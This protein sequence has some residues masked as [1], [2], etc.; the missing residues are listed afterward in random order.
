VKI[1]TRREEPWERLFLNELDTCLSLGAIGSQAYCPKLI[2]ADRERFVSA[3]EWRSGSYKGLGRFFWDI[4]AEES[5]RIVASIGW[6]RRVRPSRRAS[7]RAFEKL[8]KDL[9]ADTTLPPDLRRSVL[10]KASLGAKGLHFA[11]G[12]L[13]ASNLLLTRTDLSIIDWE[14][15]GMRLPCYDLAFLWAMGL[16]SAKHRR[17]VESAIEPGQRG[18]FWT[19]VILILLKESRLFKSVGETKPRKGSKPVPIILKELARRLS[20]ALKKLA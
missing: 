20:E 13:I 14:H 9:T 7:A 10:K 16:F 6:I 2:Y 4:T 3:W 5:K 18:L 1:L 15:S 12:D 17:V 8:T 11:H 19:N